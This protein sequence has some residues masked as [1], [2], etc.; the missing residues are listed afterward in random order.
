MMTTEP[1][2]VAER[3]DAVLVAESLRGSRDAFRQIVERYQTL[4]CSLAYSATGSV[5]ESEDAAQ[6]TF[7]AAWKDLR[8]LRE[9]DKLRSWLCGIVRNRIH[10][11]LRSDGREPARCAVAL[12]EAHDSPAP[13]A[14][15]SEQAISHEEEAI[16]WRSVEK[17]PELYREPLILFYRQHQS[18]EHVAAELELSE[19]AVKQRL[20]RGRRLLQEEVQAFVENTLRRTVPGQAF[21]GAVLAALPLA[22]GPMTAAGLGVGAK[23][24]A[25]AKSGLLAVWLGPFIGFFA[26]FASQW[27]MVCATTPKHERLGKLLKLIVTWVLLLGIPIVGESSV[28]S[29]GRHLH[30]SDE[31]FFASLACFW[32][33]WC[34]CLATWLILSFRQQLAIVL[35][36]E[37]AGKVSGQAVFALTPVQSAFLAA[38]MYLCMF[39]WFISLTWREHD[40]ITAAIVAGAALVMGVWFYLR[41]RAVSGEAAIRGAYRNMTLCCALMV[42]VINLRIDVWAAAKYGVS[43]AQVQT[44]LPLWIVPLLTFILAAWIAAAL[45]LTKPKTLP[46]PL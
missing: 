6:E 11:S 23:G 26:G 33:F 40:R 29:L 35:Q 30:W 4:I 25:A 13:E 27:M 7:L 34:I 24:T 22:A 3:N 1:M 37:E 28:Y 36:R 45:T 18:I 17:I 39:S 16:L 2:N 31:V 10:R 5:S 19:D 32:G 8:S 44:L 42:A 38:G 41:R 46:P 12:E 14:L 43:V 20:S 9:P 21:S 15:P